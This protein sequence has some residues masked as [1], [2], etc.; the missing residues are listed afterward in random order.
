MGRVGGSSPRPPTRAP[1]SPRPQGGGGGG[2]AIS[3]REGAPYRPNPPHPHTRTPSPGSRFTLL[4]DRCRIYERL[5]ALGEVFPR[6]RV[7]YH[8]DCCVGREKPKASWGPA[9]TPPP[10]AF[11]QTWKGGRGAWG[12]APS[13][14]PLWHRTTGGGGGLPAGY[15]LPPRWWQPQHSRRPPG[16]VFYPF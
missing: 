8:V 4:W 10:H 9:Q 13:Y 16:G 12:A 7:F 1:S 2:W 15:P 11:P 5:S 6:G 14:S 3:E